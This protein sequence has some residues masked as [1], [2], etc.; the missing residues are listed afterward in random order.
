MENSFVTDLQNQREPKQ[1]DCS[2]GIVPVR[3]GKVESPIDEREILVHFRFEDEIKRLIACSEQRQH[4][5]VE[6]MG[7]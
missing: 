1:E 3:R 4:K 7:A 5:L 2:S 6:P